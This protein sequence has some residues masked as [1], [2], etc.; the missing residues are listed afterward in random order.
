MAWLK[1][2]C[3]DAL[4]RKTPQSLLTVIDMKLSPVRFESKN[5]EIPPISCNYHRN[6]GGFLCTSDCVAER[7]GFSKAVCYSARAFN[8]MPE[9]VVL[10]GSYVL[11]HL[12]Q[13]SQ[14]KL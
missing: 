4:R 14:K 1:P 6:P 13:Q 10:T 3:S 9:T 5:R 7:V 12:E 11:S 8:K 2:D